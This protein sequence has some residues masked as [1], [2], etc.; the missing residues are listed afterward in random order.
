M[1]RNTLMVFQKNY[2]F[3]YI[4]ETMGTLKTNDMCMMKGY[5]N[6]FLKTFLFVPSCVKLCRQV[7]KSRIFKQLIFVQDLI[8]VFN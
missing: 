3:V 4:F 2:C 1:T 8:N 5:Y 7:S 6:L